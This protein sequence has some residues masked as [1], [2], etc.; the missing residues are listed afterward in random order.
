MIHL[1]KIPPAERPEFERLVNYYSEQL[2][3]DPNHIMQVMYVESRLNPKAENTKYPLKNGMATGL[4][5]FTPDT[6]K[7]LGTTVAQIKQ[8]T[9][10]EQLP[11]VY[12]HFKPKAGKLNTY[13]DVYLQ[14][15]FPVATGQGNNLDYVF[16]TKY[17]KRSA[18]AKSNPS[19]DINK[20]G[21][22]TMREFI[23]YLKNTTQKA[24]QPSLFKNSSFSL[25]AFF[26]ILFA[27]TR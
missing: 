19:I 22:I 18:V 14:V 12:K 11:Y 7:G 6:A 16:E 26:L 9:R 21:T 27:L 5:Q 23:Q 15:F 20:D 1:D 2:G 4:I 8:M 25:L 10:S 24:L 13:Q 3:A 17:L